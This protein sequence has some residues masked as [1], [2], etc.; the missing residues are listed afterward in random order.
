[1][2][3]CTNE[4]SSETKQVQEEQTSHDSL[5]I[6][7]AKLSEREKNIVNQLV[8]DFKTF[9][10]IDGVVKEGEVLES[11]IVKYENG[12]RKGV[13][14]AS[15]SGTGERKKYDKALHSFQIQMEEETAYL[16]IG[17]PNGYARGSTTMLDDLGSFTFEEPEEEI[18]LTKGEPIH[19]AY[20]VGTSQN[21]LSSVVNEDPA[22]L[23]ESVKNAEYAIVFIV[24]L[25]DNS[26]NR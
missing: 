6:K 5:K 23:P 25:R 1:M 24:E 20:M 8:G 16:T 11:S 18:T 7:P 12:E 14:L 15:V 4:G 9:Y 10:T 19:L 21:Q 22:T 17:G 3:G 13:K 2:V 26:E